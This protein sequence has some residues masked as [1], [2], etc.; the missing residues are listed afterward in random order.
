MQL[1]KLGPNLRDL[2]FERSGFGQHGAHCVAASFTA[3]SK[4]TTEG[5]DCFRRHQ[6][7]YS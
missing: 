3:K 6:G 5:L 7:V 4:P 1:S 2:A